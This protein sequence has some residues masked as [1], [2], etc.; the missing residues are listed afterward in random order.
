MSNKIN[1]SQYNTIL[2]ILDKTKSCRE[3]AIEMDMSTQ[4]MNASINFLHNHGAV[5]K[6]A[7]R[8]SSAR[9]GYERLKEF[10]LLSDVI[11]GQSDDEV[12]DE[13]HYKK[14]GKIISFDNEE[15]RKKLNQTQRQSRINK[16]VH[17]Y[18]SGSTL[19]VNA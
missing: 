11:R 7:Y 17:H 3:L 14:F 5:K 13:S 16:T 4:S 2:A 10:I 9:I 19:S 1:I 8:T 6:V 15:M 18:V 12:V